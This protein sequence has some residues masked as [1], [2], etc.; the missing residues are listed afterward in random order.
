MK[1]I[2]DLREDKDPLGSSSQNKKK[3]VDYISEQVTLNLANSTASNYNFQN[4]GSNQ[5]IIFESVAKIIAEIFVD[6]SDF[7]DDIS[8]SNL[9]SE[10]I[11]NKLLSLVFED[12]NIPN[13][14]DSENL[15]YLCQEVVQSLLLGSTE[16]SI[17]KALESTKDG[18]LIELR[19]I[20][21]HVISIY[22]STLKYTSNPLDTTTP[23]HR[24]V[25]FAKSN[26]VG[27]TSAPIGKNW[28]E[29]LHYHEVV[30]GV[31]QP[32]N[33]HTHD[34][35]LGISSTSLEEQENLRKVL[36]T[37]KPAHLKIGEVSS[38][39]AERIQP[40][41]GS[42][43]NFKKEG[44]VISVVNPEKEEDFI[45]SLG[46]SYQENMRKVRAGTWENVVFGYY[47]D[48]K[49]RVSN[50]L[51][52]PLDNIS[53]GG[54][55]RKVSEVVE[56]SIADGEYVANLLRHNKT[57]TVNVL[58]GFISVDETIGNNEVF[59][60][61]GEC[62]F[63]EKRAKGVSYLKAIEIR[64][65]SSV[66][67]GEGLNEVSFLDLSWYSP[68]SLKY[69]KA[70]IRVREHGG[71]FYAELNVPQRKTFRGLPIL[72][73]D[74]IIDP[75][76]VLLEYYPYFLSIAGL[77]NK[78]VLKF[79]NTNLT[80]GQEIEILCPLGED[81]LI[82][83]TELNS[84]QFVLNASR[85]TRRSEKAPSPSK[86]ATQSKYNSSSSPTVG[87]YPT[88][89]RQPFNFETFKADSTSLGTFGL[90]TYDPT[91]IT[92]PQ[93]NQLLV[94]L[95]SKYNSY[96]HFTL[97]TYNKVSSN[98]SD[99]KDYAR[100]T[101]SV[102]GGVVS[103]NALGFR[104]DFIVSVLDS[105]LREYL[106]EI[107]P[108]GLK[109]F[110]AEEGL[111]VTVTSISTN[112][113][114]KSTWAKGNVLSE[115]QAPFD[116]PEKSIRETTSFPEDIMRNPQ[117]RVLDSSDFAEDEQRLDLYHKEI[118]SEGVVAEEI[119]YEDDLTRLE[120]KGHPFIRN[121][122]A[123][124]PTVKVVRPSL[125]TNTSN[126][127]IGIRSVL[128]RREVLESEGLRIKLIPKED[129]DLLSRFF[130]G[131]FLEDQ[132]N[133]NDA[134]QEIP[135]ISFK[136][137]QDVGDVLNINDDGV[138]LEFNLSL[139]D[140]VPLIQD[141]PLVIGGNFLLGENLED[142]VSISDLD[143][144]DTLYLLTP[145]DEDVLDTVLV[146]D[147]LIDT[148]FTFTISENLEDGVSIS[149]IEPLGTE[150]LYTPSDEDVSDI[151][152]NTDEPVETD[153][154]FTTD[155]FLTDTVVISDVMNESD[156]VTYQFNPISET[157]TVVISDV[158]NESDL[159]SYQFNPISETDTLT[160][161]DVMNESDLTSYQFN[162][163]SETDTLTISDAMNE[164]D[165]VS[166]QYNPVSETD[167][168][169]IS[170]GVVNAQL[171]F[172][173]VPESTV[174]DVVSLQDDGASAEFRYYLPDAL[175]QDVVSVTDQEIDL[176]YAPTLI[177]S[178]QM[179]E[180]MADYDFNITIYRVPEEQ[181]LNGPYYKLDYPEIVASGQ[182]SNSNQTPSFEIR[183]PTWSSNI[184][185][186][187]KLSSI[188][189]D[190]VIESG[191]GANV[192]INEQYSNNHVID[193]YVGNDSSNPILLN[194][195]YYMLITSQGENDSD[196]AFNLLPMNF[197]VSM[198]MV[199][200]SPS[201]FNLGTSDT[202]DN[203]GELRGNY[204]ELWESTTNTTQFI[205]SSLPG[206]NH[207]NILT[208][209]TRVWKFETTPHYD[210]RING[211][212][213][214]LS[215]YNPY[216]THPAR[217]PMERVTNLTNAPIDHTQIY[218]PIPVED[219]TPNQGGTPVVLYLGLFISWNSN[220]DESI[221]I[222]ERIATSSNSYNVPSY[223][224]ELF[225][226][227]INGY[228]ST[229]FPDTE[230]S[231]TRTITLKNT[232]SPFTDHNAP[233]EFWIH[234]HKHYHITVSDP[235]KISIHLETRLYS[236]SYTAY[237]AANPPPVVNF[238]TL[239]NNSNSFLFYIRQDGKIY[240]K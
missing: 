11:A 231:G 184:G 84:E 145:S 103:F 211:V 161:S 136:D 97:N 45:F 30:D 81:D 134:D 187:F 176:D 66:D 80:E 170:E 146:S 99:I 137:H 148:E 86:I 78:I 236:D 62:Y 219:T 42:T 221:S 22:S 57:L 206:T 14:K 168:L 225:P 72:K 199:F 112:P 131:V 121:I 96:T 196:A 32:Y 224:S 154:R 157:D 205:L 178:V 164:S 119:F 212:A 220:S 126:T 232:L 28:G 109:V 79:E 95:N 16:E 34:V 33:G 6:I 200:K 208:T 48:Q 116:F 141:N 202:Q 142:G 102:F 122:K 47:K 106:Y 195:T 239:T 123:I 226:H 15:R 98:V 188:G 110:G 181:N 87:L 88:L 173:P 234:S 61:D 27:A 153:Y 143:P 18:D 156:L 35:E 174:D 144:L 235:S 183:N 43:V 185:N 182:T 128:N 77:S 49:I 40:P 222:E 135:L 100:K 149:D 133:I 140:E 204:V 113:Y 158:M 130:F 67:V 10:F 54:K 19:Q 151:V 76:Y 179:D 92:N 7:E 163:I 63:A 165:L 83:F 166:Y 240:I 69:R 8:F 60:I 24:H 46:G 26:G 152:S 59:V 209:E 5:R 228:T 12:E 58:N 91:D 180:R 20:S 38:V 37:T 150:Y 198:Q 125:M 68:T 129:I 201:S 210:T 155:E 216:N 101:L 217:L 25:V 227:E 17:L 230:S 238:N 108:R 215:F 36:R 55:I 50:A 107:T 74:F 53:V 192:Y 191:S 64:L 139:E 71:F 56:V 189:G 85:K 41:S 94:G 171:Q 52:K 159:V 203:M 21:Q 23:M 39:L 44:G 169:N 114:K 104:P 132:V 193:L 105:D 90:N 223:S 73:E 162:P 213:S 229:D 75:Q 93:R 237:T 2:P 89:P 138:S 233:I 167:D 218:P 115:G 124:K 186:D 197:R 70:V 65:A 82:N 127:L 160:I 4:Y 120:I 214:S 172:L 194:E 13:I 147:E 3:F 118:T 29:E 1:F 31:V 207:F 51:V 175:Q 177:L 9:R 190:Q 117:G 111:E